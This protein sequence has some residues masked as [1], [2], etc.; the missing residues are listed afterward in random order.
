[1]KAVV[2][3]PPGLVEN[4]SIGLRQCPVLKENECLVKVYYSA[5]NRADTLQRQGNLGLSI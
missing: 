5:I 1:M 3:S 4:L 2:Y